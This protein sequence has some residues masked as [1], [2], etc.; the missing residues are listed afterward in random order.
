MIRFYFKGTDI[1]DTLTADGKEH[2]KGLR[3]RL[4]YTS[5]WTRSFVKTLSKLIFSTLEI[6]ETKVEYLK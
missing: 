1:V 4:W 5:E 2:L 6:L 3:L